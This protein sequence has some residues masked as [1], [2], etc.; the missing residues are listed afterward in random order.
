MTDAEIRAKYYKYKTWYNK[1]KI[2]KLLGASTDI[3]SMDKLS[4]EFINSKSADFRD[5]AIKFIEHLS[6]K[7]DNTE[8][9]KSVP[10]YQKFLEKYRIKD[11]FD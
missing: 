5:I 2:I 10:N 8:L 1:G 9:L 4:F 6:G 7:F 3:N 11:V